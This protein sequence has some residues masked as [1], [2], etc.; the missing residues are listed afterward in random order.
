[1]PPPLQFVLGGDRLGLRLQQ[2][3]LEDSWEKVTS[4]GAS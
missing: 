3:K 2:M 4:K 1:M